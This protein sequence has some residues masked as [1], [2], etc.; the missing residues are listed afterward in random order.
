MDFQELQYRINSGSYSNTRV[1][2]I[3]RYANSKYS[4]Y[5]HDEKL[6]FEEQ[7]RVDS[8][9]F[10]DCRRA[11]E[12]YL[13]PLTRDQWKM[14]WENVFQGIDGQTHQGIFNRLVALAPLAENLLYIRKRRVN[15]NKELSL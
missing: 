5:N 12:N 1:L 10:T 4:D 6:F 3:R 11:F 14:V 15:R 8:L 7:E 13:H 9:F 2:P